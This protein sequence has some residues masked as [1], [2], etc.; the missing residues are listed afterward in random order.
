VRCG[1][2]ATAGNGIADHKLLSIFAHGIG[3]VNPA[4]GVPLP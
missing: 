1:K 3:G 4:A 2:R